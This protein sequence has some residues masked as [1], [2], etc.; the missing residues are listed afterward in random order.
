MTPLVQTAAE[1]RNACAEARM[2]GPLALVPTMGYLHEGHVSLIRAAALTG[3]QVAVTIFVN[4]TQFGPNEDL[5]SYPRDLRGDLEKCGQ[6]GASFA[7]VPRAPAE[8]FPPGFQTWVEPGPLAAPLCG[9]RR[10]GHFRGVCTVVAKL[11]ALS[12][13]DRAFFGEKDFQQLLVIRQMARDLDLATEVIGRPIVR[14]PDGVAL[15]SRN[16]YL[17]AEERPRAVALW[18]ALGAVRALFQAGTREPA[19]LEQ[20]AA[21]A[22]ERAGLRVDYAEVRDPRDLERPQ[23]AS[24]ETRLFLAAFLGKTRLIDNGAVGDPH[25]LG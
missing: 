19:A 16:A 8:L 5:S 18:A 25:R 22:I 20:A 6:A 11:F 2:D 10:P 13:A 3:K 9:A 24:L 15:S 4:P 23:G 7:F 1:F 17:T 14:E 21:Q 12:R